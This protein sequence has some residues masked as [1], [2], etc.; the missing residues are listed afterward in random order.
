MCGLNR[1]QYGDRMRRFILVWMSLCA[2]LNGTAGIA[3]SDDA[4]DAE[5]R[6]A[7]LARMK[8]IAEKFQVGVSQ[9]SRPAAKL[10]EKPVLRYSDSTRRNGES[11]LWMWTERELPVALMGV[12]YYPKRQPGSRWLFEIASLSDARIGVARGDGWK[13]EAR[14]AGLVRQAVPESPEP[15][16]TAALRLSQGRQ[17]RQRFTA[18]ETEGTDGRVELRPLSNPLYRYKDEMTGVVDGMI[19][20]YANGTNPE[21]LLI[22]EVVRN[23]AGGTVGWT[24]GFAQ[25]TGAKVH[26]SLDAREVWTQKEADPP[27]IRESYVNG[28]LADE[29][30]SEEAK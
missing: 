6:A 13:W 24:Y 28:W 22:L 5:L 15:P 10:N 8:A 1:R 23:Q 20:A 11:T 30:K 7:Q 14:Q 27:A 3:L 2:I 12:E 16:E 9:P 4:T 19:F 29:S 17:I 25:M 26:V 18:H 21:V